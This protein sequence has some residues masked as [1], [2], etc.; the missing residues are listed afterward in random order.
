MEAYGLVN[1]QCQFRYNHVVRDAPQYMIP[2][3]HFIYIF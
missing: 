1:I 2:A 3:L